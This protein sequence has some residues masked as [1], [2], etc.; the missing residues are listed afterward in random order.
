MYK[1]LLDKVYQQPELLEPIRDMELVEKHKLLIEQ[2]M[3]TVFPVT[4]SD[5]SDY[6][7]AGVP[8]QFQMF[9]A[10]RKMQEEFLDNS[11]S[12]IKAP[13]CDTDDRIHIEKITGAYQM[14]LNRFL[15]PILIMVL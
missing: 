1:E 14:I 4:L 11:G 6:Y 15:M 8:F 5:K 12:K 3:S 10:S 13:D 2:L 9:Y 7:G